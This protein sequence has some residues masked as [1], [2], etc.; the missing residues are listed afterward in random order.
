MSDSDI[1]SLPS[2]N[3]SRVRRS[4]AYQWFLVLAIVVSIGAASFYFLQKSKSVLTSQAKNSAGPPTEPPPPRTFELPAQP[5]TT[6]VPEV[7]DV[8]VQPLPPPTLSSQSERPITTGSPSALPP[9]RMMLTENSGPTTISGGVQRPIRT[10]QEYGR[11]PDRSPDRLARGAEPSGA[12]EG[13]LQELLQPIVV[14]SEK[15]MHLGDRSLMLAKGYT[16]DCILNTHLVST[17]PGMTSCV[18]SRDVFS[19]NGKVLLIEKGSLITGQYSAT[20][21]FGRERIFVLWDRIKTV[22]GVIIQ[23]T[24]PAA[25]ELGAAG[26]SGDVDNHWMQRIGAAVMLSLVGDAIA[27]KTAQESSRNNSGGSST[28]VL[29]NTSRQAETLAGKILDKTINI[30]PTMSRNQGGR[31]SVFVARDLDFGSVYELR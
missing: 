19:D 30:P 23:V 22:Q 24:S 2:V 8:S 3:Q 28:I 9:D 13:S 11:T 27:Y 7:S 10:G 29:P 26:I 17:V 20:L 21:Q 1:R 14:K 31:V 18:V 5:A 15:A 16:I 25:D 4:R 12:Q 6:P